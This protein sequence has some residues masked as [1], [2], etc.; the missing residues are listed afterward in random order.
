MFTGIIEEVGR[1]VE[2]LSKGGNLQIRIEAPA[3]ATELRINDS[4][5]V[6]GACQTVVTK[7]GDVFEVVAVEETLL[8]TTLGSLRSGSNVNIELPMR[9]NARL[10]GHLVLGHIDT[11]GEILDIEDRDGSTIL[12]FRV[13][14]LFNKYLVSIGSIA[15]DGVSL[16]LAEV[17]GS[18]A[19]VSII[20][21]TLQNTI[22]LEY[23]IGSRVNVEFDI[24][25]KY[26][27]RLISR[28]DEPDPVKPIPDQA[29]LREMGY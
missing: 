1:V 13:T 9:L 6:N 11:V 25:G 23:R 16:T 3:S 21:H 7:Q 4:V 2:V 24:I 17:D 22:F 12:R 29:R 5:S 26:V 18:T 19:M 10:G 15:I 28:Q 8:K 14:D 20:P 27:E